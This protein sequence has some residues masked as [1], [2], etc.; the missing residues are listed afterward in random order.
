MTNGVR[1]LVN[2]SNSRGPMIKGFSFRGFL[3]GLPLECFVEKVIL[4]NLQSMD[5]LC[6]SNQ[7]R[8]RIKGFDG[9]F[10]MLKTM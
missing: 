5:G 6:V 8:P 4:R 7:E 2:L 1:S 9:V 10:I 3:L